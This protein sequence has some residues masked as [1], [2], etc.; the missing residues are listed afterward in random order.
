[1]WAA[2][3]SLPG[4]GV[5]PLGRAGAYVASGGGDLNSLW[6]NP[7]NLAGMEELQ[8]T[9]DAGLINLSFDFQRAP[10]TL[11][12][13]EVRT[14]EPVSNEAP[15]KI[16]P[17]ILIGGPLSKP[18]GL[19]WAFGAY[20]PYL[21]GHVFPENG[22]QRYTM[23]DNDAS[24]LLYTH[25][26]LSWA[27]NDWVR[28]GAGLQNVWASF[29]VINVT[30]A[31]TGLYGDPE[32]EDL[33]I[34]TRITLT[35]LFNPTANAGV[36]VKIAPILEG[37]LSIQ[38]P[39]QIRDDEA[40]IETRLPDNAFFANAEIQGDRIAGQ[41]ELPFMARVGLRLVPSEKFDYELSLVWENWSTLQGIDATPRNVTVEGV[42]G[43]GSIA[44]APLSVPLGYQDTYSIRNGA[45]YAI[46]ES[47]RARAGYT[48]ESSAVPDETYS[49]FLAEGNKHLFALGGSWIGESWSLDASLAYYLIPDRTI[50]NS[51]V[52]QINPT[53]A[54]G[55]NTL[56]V[57]NG[58][59]A[60]TYVV[61]GVGLNKKF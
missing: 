13:G 39:V 14:Y 37:A 6:Y 4:R 35:S 12:N 15:P 7:A 46:S 21:S 1:M 56:I 50:T 51:E 33:D 20:A 31:Y 23:V 16:S 8:L 57:G 42:P 3:F 43:V 5:R 49:V 45:E 26:A 36:W 29:S 27:P 55:E 24:V 30:S 38:L 22:P 59:Y 60:Q 61:G 19:T 11:D 41:M 52:R 25:A 10:R 40:Q 44:I 28:V 32:D 18:Y 9:V 47:L 2:G 17:Q 58:D 54:E 48:F 34:L 53:D